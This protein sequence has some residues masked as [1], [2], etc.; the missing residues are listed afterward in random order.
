MR[1]WLLVILG[2]SACQLVG[3]R[4]PVVFDGVPPKKMNSAELFMVKGDVIDQKVAVLGSFRGV[5]ELRF[6]DVSAVPLRRDGDHVIVQGPEGELR[7]PISEITEVTVTGPSIH[8]W[9]VGRRATT[10]GAGTGLVLGGAVFATL[11]L[12]GDIRVPE[13]IAPLVTLGPLFVGGYAMVGAAVGFAVGSLSSGDL[14]LTTDQGWVP[15]V[16]PGKSTP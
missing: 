4:P 6:G 16:P 10:W 8:R 9:K 1:R 12:S 7:A 15:V 2:L 3:P 5:R 13:D 14:T 11:V